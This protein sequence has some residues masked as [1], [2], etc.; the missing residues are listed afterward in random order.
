MQARCLAAVICFAACASLMAQQAP[1]DLQAQAEAAQ[2]KKRAELFM[3]MAKQRL[4]QAS[5][6]FNEGKTEEAHE[7]VKKAVAASQE[8][9]DAARKS[10][11]RLKQ[12]EIS[13]RQ[14]ARRLADL[15]NTLEFED[16]EAIK[17]SVEKLEEIRR[18]LLEEMFGKKKKIQS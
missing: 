5:R 14:V 6:L 8:A 9:S 11:K 16:R 4:D 2:G 17:A 18:Q 3:E 10:H 7:A 12:T 15:S 13:V 1:P